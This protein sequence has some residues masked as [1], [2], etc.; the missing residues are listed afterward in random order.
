MQ[1]NDIRLLLSYTKTK[2]TWIKNLNMT[3]EAPKRL[4]TNIGSALHDVGAENDFQTRAPF[5]QELRQTN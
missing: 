4:K 2:S 1:K 5:V 3:S